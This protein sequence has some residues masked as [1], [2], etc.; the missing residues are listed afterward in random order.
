M[1][2]ERLITN[3]SGKQIFVCHIP[4]TGKRKRRGRFVPWCLALREE[5]K[6]RVFEKRV[7]RGI[8]GLKRAR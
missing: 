2:L 5:H 4:Y 8:F 1:K 6:V 7:L 3:V